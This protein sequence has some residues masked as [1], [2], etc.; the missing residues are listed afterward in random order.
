MTSPHAAD[1]GQWPVCCY[2]VQC[3]ANIS[4]LQNLV[5]DFQMRESIH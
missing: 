1:K 5:F 3:R 4:P 2:T